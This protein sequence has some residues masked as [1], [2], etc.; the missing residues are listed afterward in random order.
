MAR[1][2]YRLDLESKDSFKQLDG[3]E[4]RLG[5]LGD[6]VKKNPVTAF[7]ALGAAALAAGVQLARMA[8]ETNKALAAIADRIPGAEGRVADLRKEMNR[9]AIEF[10]RSQDAI[11]DTLKASSAAGAETVEELIAVT[12]AALGLS[13]ALGGS[14]PNALAGQL[15]TVGDLFNI[16]ADDL[17]AFGAALFSITKGKADVSEILSTLAVAGRT[18]EGTGISALTAASAFTQLNRELGVSGKKAITEFEE[19]LRTGGIKAIEDLAAKAP[20]AADAFATYTEAVRRNNDTIEANTERARAQ[21]RVIELEVGTK[22]SALGDIGQKVLFYTLGGGWT[23]AARRAKEAADATDGAAG[24]FDR[25][26]QSGGAVAGAGAQISAT[27]VEATTAVSDFAKKSVP[28]L[29][30]YKK[31]LEEA[32]KAG[33]LDADTKRTLIAVNKE[34]EKR[35]DEGA[36][37]AEAA[38]KKE[39]EA[40]KRRA[41]A[42][43]DALASIRKTTIAFT[44]TL[45]DDTVEA[46]NELELG[47]RGAGVSAEEAAEALKPLQEQLGLIKVN[48]N[49]KLPE[50]LEKS[51]RA[52]SQLDVQRLVSAQAQLQALYNNA[53][54]AGKTR[55]AIAKQQEAVDKK[56][57]EHA[58][59]IAES[60]QT[61]AIQSLDLVDLAKRHG[62]ELG[63]IPPVIGSANEKLEKQVREIADVA[64]GAIGVADAFGLIDDNAAK[65]LGQIVAIGAA[66]P[67]AFSGDPSAIIGVIGSLA[68]VISSLF[69]TGPEEAARRALVKRNTAALEELTSGVVELAKVTGGAEDVLGIQQALEAAFKRSKDLPFVHPGFLTEELFKRGLSREDLNELAKS[70]GFDLGESGNAISGLKDLLEF[71]R[72]GKFSL[73]GPD[74]E[75]QLKRIREAIGLG[76][77]GR[78]SE[79]GAILRAL[80]ETGGGPAILQAL[81]G[82]DLGTAEGRQ[83]AL[84][85]LRDLFKEISTKQFTGA[86]FAGI[87]GTLNSQQLVDVLG[88]LI[89]ILA[90]PDRTIAPIGDIT[91]DRP[92]LDV[93]DETASFYSDSL[94]AAD[95]QV[96]LLT[97]ALVLESRQAAALDAILASLTS[98]SP[99]GPPALPDSVLAGAGASVG[100]T[101]VSLQFAAGSIV[102]QGVSDPTAAAEELADTIW[103]ITDQRLADRFRDERRIRGLA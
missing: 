94:T 79:F 11:V 35:H 57:A 47:L 20:L 81:E 80:G 84:T 53:D 29:N 19:R 18:L 25:L 74:F 5:S 16:A 8:D 101:S 103:R 102:V 83:A 26:A 69:G 82:R 33:K 48:E 3:V 15:D 38:A 39:E 22:L 61:Q 72:T 36:K 95:V 100:S 58:F 23:E 24:A 44:A 87:A 13:A 50:I 73:F 2:F 14:D 37:A 77:L 71:L 96:G 12:E 4:K 30:R 21:G 31:A 68:G 56:L 62:V 28:D 67:K 92:P 78:E 46:I 59:A 9:L 43:N 91:P 89:A 70:L 66:L 99:I 52:L 51:V 10:G 40:A 6:F 76:T 88:D 17:D 64:L 98:F 45:V 90:D 65:V 85:A 63:K 7:G 93:A 42:Y 97:D 60:Q 27:I 41:K 1:L 54:A 75:G 34:L 55:L 86:E 49:L 32:D